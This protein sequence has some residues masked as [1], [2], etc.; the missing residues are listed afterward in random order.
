[1]RIFHA[2]IT[3]DDVNTHRENKVH[4]ELRASRDPPVAKDQVVH[5]DS[6]DDQAYPVNRCALI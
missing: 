1:M 5:Q 3:V 2:V 4:K 6:L